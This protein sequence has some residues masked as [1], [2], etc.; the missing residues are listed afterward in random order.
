MVALYE[1]WVRQYP[2]VSIEDGL[3]EGD[4]DGWQALTKA[5]GD[6]VQ[7][8]GDDLFVTNPEILK[9]G[10]S[11]GVANSI[12]IKLNQIGTV[13]RD[14]RRRRDGH[15][16]G[17]HAASSRTAPARPKTRRSRTSR[18]PPRAGRSRPAR[19]AAAI[20]SPST[21]SCCASRKSSPGADATPAAPPSSSSPRPSHADPRS[22]S[23]RRKH[24]E[25]GKPL[26]RLDGRRSL[27]ARPAG[28]ARGRD[29]C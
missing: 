9:R 28:S 12:L 27:R 11:E 4:W 29:V 21:T 6:R 18:S 8:V 13:T 26:H 7:L 17:L 20:A 5:L 22:A 2:I 10:I 25:Q 16:R 23:A 19:R 24:L 14:A 1:D 3:A 15:G